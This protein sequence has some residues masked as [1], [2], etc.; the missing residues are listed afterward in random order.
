M[1]FCVV[2]HDLER[3]LGEQ[4]A[5]EMR[6]EAEEREAEIYRRKRCRCGRFF[7]PTHA[8]SFQCRRCMDAMIG[9]SV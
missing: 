3:Y 6:A 7:S 9:G 1:S 4:E 5:A 8:M 2:T